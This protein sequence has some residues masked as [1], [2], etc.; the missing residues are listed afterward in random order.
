MYCMTY[1]AFAFVY[2]CIFI[3][4]VYTETQLEDLPDVLDHL[5]CPELKQL[6]KELKLA[7]P[8][9]PSVTKASLIKLLLRHAR[10]HRPLF[11]SAP[12]SSAALLKK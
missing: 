11:A 9:K 1:S 3:L 12:S 4:C 7:A 8:T 10:Q 2:V 5:Q 6:C